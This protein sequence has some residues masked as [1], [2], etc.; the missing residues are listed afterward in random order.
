MGIQCF[1]RSASG[2]FE[3]K[4]TSFPVVW[5]A[6]RVE[7]DGFVKRVQINR[8]VPYNTVVGALSAVG[9]ELY[10][11]LS[12]G[13]SVEVPGLGIF[14]LNVK[15]KAN[16]S[17][18]GGLKLDDAKLSVRFRPL[19]MARKRLDRVRVSLASNNVMSCGELTQE[20]ALEAARKLIDERGCFT[21]RQLARAV[22]VSASTA[23]RML[24]KLQKSGLVNC[25]CIGKVNVY[26]RVV[27]EENADDAKS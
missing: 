3:G 20:H 26:N 1:I 19:G 25:V 17:D 16:E 27:A 5:D 10:T 7:A 9:A 11:L 15:G 22:D 12:H 6:G 14:S 2:A 23:S 24:R 13:H 21:Q 18:G 8:N 4:R